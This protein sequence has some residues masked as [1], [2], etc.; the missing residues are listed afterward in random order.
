MGWNLNCM[1]KLSVDRALMKAQSHAKKGEWQQ[2]RQLY[3]E[4]L[5]RF[6]KNTRAQKGLLDIVGRIASDHKIGSGIYRADGWQPSL[7]SRFTG[8]GHKNLSRV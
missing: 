4:V 3:E 8:I 1:T 2:A 7:F 6:P 5:L